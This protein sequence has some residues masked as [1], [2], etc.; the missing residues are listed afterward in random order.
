MATVTGRVVKVIKP[1]RFKD[2]EFKR[3]IRNAMKR[4]SRRMKKEFEKTTETWEHPVKFDEHTNLT[5]YGETPSVS[6]TT[7]NEIYG[8]VNNGTEPHEIWAGAYT[9]KSEAKLLVFGSYFV[10]KTKVRVIGSEPGDKGGPMVGVPMVNHP[11]TEAREFDKAIQEEMTPWFKK[12][13]EQAMKDGA[14]ASGHG[15]S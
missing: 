1:A 14:K 8:Y 7:D 9:G 4:F 12:E 10:P 5:P 11:G 2:Q 15:M 6:V 3:E 13:M